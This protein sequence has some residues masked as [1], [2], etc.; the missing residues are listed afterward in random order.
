MWQKYSDSSKH[1]I[2]FEG[3]VEIYPSSLIQKSP[4]KE[5]KRNIIR[6]NFC[7]PSTFWTYV[8]DWTSLVMYSTSKSMGIIMHNIIQNI[9]GVRT[10]RTRARTEPAAA[11]APNL[12]PANP[13]E[14]S[15]TVVLCGPLGCFWQP[16]RH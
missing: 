11:T 2:I 6:L 5:F 12:S 10:L 4:N 15:S 1:L 8:Y 16:Q 9:F 14:L 13:T 7:H 3:V